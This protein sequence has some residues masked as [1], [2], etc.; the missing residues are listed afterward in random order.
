MHFSVLCATCVGLVGA[1]ITW[2]TATAA[3]QVEGFRHADGRQPSIWD[4][5]DT[6][7]VSSTIKSYKPNGKVN[8]YHGENA[9]QATMD[10]IKYADSAQLTR[11]YGFGAARLSIS[12]T[13]VMT[14]SIDPTHGGLVATVN[15]KGI[16]HYKQVLLE[17]K[18]NGIQ[19][20]VTIWHWDTPLI[21]EEFASKQD[22]GSAWL[23]HNWFP[24]LFAEY[25]ALLLSSYGHLAD[26]W[27]TIN[28]PLTIVSNCYQG[29]GAHAPGR[30]SNRE[31]CWSG[32]DHTEPYAVAKG[33]IL[34]H[35]HAFRTW[36]KFGRPGKGCGI[37]CN[38]DWRIPFT[39]SE[40]DLAAATRSLEW[41][42]PIFFDPIY[43]GTWPSS[44]VKAVGSRLPTWSDEEL[45]LVKGAHD[46]HFFMNSYTTNFAR[47][48]ED[49]GCGWSCDAGAEASGYNW[50]SGEPVGKPSSN[51]WLF[52]YGPGL[53][54]LVN[55][56]HQRWPSL[57]FVITENGW[58][59]ASSTMKLELEVDDLE[60]CNFYRDYL[61][62]LSAIAAWKDI[63]ID[64]YFAWSLMDNYEW[65][66]G[67][68]VRFGLTY[69]NYKTQQRIPKMSARWFQKYVTPLTELP[70]DGKPLPPCNPSVLHD[71]AISV[72]V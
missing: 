17:Y 37:T 3:Y 69:V 21:I 70:T 2:G 58:G 27:I 28:E 23:C 60:R 22:C 61:G 31:T 36:E 65:A 54:E 67:F 29:A 41:Q 44:V 40:A 4:A 66:D 20:A 25:S 42:A 7:N 35:A 38:G 12:W 45:R 62:N 16:E 30:C 51:G 11:Q 24:Q 8:I 50:T 10:Y 57:S 32:D 56:Y 14:Y 64:A 15:E 43:F 49:K 68:S 59:N 47:A 46:S 33:L 19:T 9:G 5:F 55:W 63:Q 6:P 52:N 53:G 13:R 72:I 1:K 39:S 18:R 48:V 26:W 34:A 71:A